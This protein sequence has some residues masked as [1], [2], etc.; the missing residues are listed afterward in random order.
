MAR[1]RLSDERIEK[2]L[3]EVRA[4]EARIEEELLPT[5]RKIGDAISG[6]GRNHRHGIPDDPKT[7]NFNFLLST[8]NTMVPAI[9]SMDPYIGFEPRSISDK[10]P[11]SVAEA[12]VNYCYRT[13]RANDE[14]ALILQDAFAYSGGVGKVV[15]N[16][17]GNVTPVL[18]Y[19]QD[20]S[21]DLIFED[22]G[23][24]MA[25]VAEEMSDDEVAVMQMD[26]GIDIPKLER[27]APWNWLYPEGHDDPNRCPWLAHKMHVRLEDLRMYEGFTVKSNITANQESRF[28]AASAS[29]Q[30]MLKWQPGALDPAFVTMYEIH[31]WFRKGNRLSRRILWLLDHT[32]ARGFDRVV[33]HAEDDSGMRGYPFVLLRTVRTPGKMFDPGIADLA[34][35]APIADKLNDELRNVLRHHERASKHK[36]VTLPGAMDG[37]KIGDLLKS[38]HDMH[39]VEAPSNVDD[40]RKIMA[41]VEVAPLPPDTPFIIQTLHRFMY[42]ISGVDSF[43][44]GGVSRKGTTATEVAVAAQGAQSRAAVRKRAVQRFVEDIARRYLDCL[45]RFWTEPMWISGSGGADEFIEVSAEKMRGLFDI[46]VTV[47]DFDPN[48]QANELQAF[49]GLLQTIGATAGTLSP[50]VQAGILPPESISNFINQAFTLW[51]QDKRRLIGPLSSMASPV[52]Q[53]PASPQAMG[54]QPSASGTG[55]GLPGDD[56]VASQ[57]DGQGAAPQGSLGLVLGLAGN[58]PRPRPGQGEEN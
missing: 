40:V 54:A 41:M 20:A 15:Y 46:K 38:E 4:S 5:W 42:E 35:M 24:D 50:L 22:D 11:S 51:K 7:V 36:Y 33:R 31:Y 13:G 55:A 6:K 34:S 3:T 56:P 26:D 44:R 48:E 28:T 27:I 19:D 53:S 12:S 39:A 49:T 17:A 1:I 9:L 52:V 37:S 18:H 43:Q 8:Q 30:D 14:V 58:G 29:L 10:D 21:I 47:G 25:V 32:S 2:F 16:P 45:R 57:I 23:I